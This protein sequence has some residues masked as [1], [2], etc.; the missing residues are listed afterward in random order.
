MRW[1]G[2]RE[3]EEGVSRRSSIIFQG[4]RGPSGALLSD[5]SKAPRKDTLLRS[6][7]VLPSFFLASFLLH[8]LSVFDQGPA[9]LYLG[10][11]KHVVP[12]VLLACFA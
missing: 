10:K 1:E 6:P 5:S 8:E 4:P 7:E 3:R 12:T 2:E 11:A 9:S